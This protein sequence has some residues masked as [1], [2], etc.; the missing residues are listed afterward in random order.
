MDINY[1]PYQWDFLRFRKKVESYI[2]PEPMSGCWLW[3]GY[4]S[5]NGYGLI[6]KYGRVWLAHRV[7]Y[8]I[9]KA[10]ITNDEF[11]EPYHVCHRC[12]NRVCVNPDHLFL[13][14]VIE[15]IADRH[16]KGRTRPGRGERHGRAKLTAAQVTAIRQDTRSAPKVAADYG[17]SKSSILFIR[18]GRTWKHDR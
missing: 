10:P 11:G 16:Q 15:N 13:G 18:Q 8:V 17:V 14:T 7:T 12:D 1:I 6:G 2:F 5:P 4:I 9:F 3:D